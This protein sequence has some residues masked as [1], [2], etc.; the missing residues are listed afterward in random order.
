MVYLTTPITVQLITLSL[1]GFL[2]GQMVLLTTQWDTAIDPSATTL[3]CSVVVPAHLQSFPVARGTSTGAWP[4]GDRDLLP[5]AMACGFLFTFY[6]Y[7]WLP[8]AWRA[9]W[10]LIRRRR[11]WAR[12]A[13]GRPATAG[14]AAE[15]RRTVACHHS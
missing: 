4:T 15:G 13:P 8:V 11:G 2:P 14:G 1:L 10:R 5:R 7:V 3:C 9:T 6:N 12:P